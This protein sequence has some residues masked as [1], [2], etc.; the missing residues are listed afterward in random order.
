MNIRAMVLGRNF[1]RQRAK[2][3]RRDESGENLD[4]GLSELAFAARG[5]Y[6]RRVYENNH[7]LFIVRN[8]AFCAAT[9]NPLTR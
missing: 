8:H 7:E 9:V 2:V 3:T 4:A 1:S 5:M 6:K